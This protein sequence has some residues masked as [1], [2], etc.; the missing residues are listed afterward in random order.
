M[1]VIQIIYYL[2]GH[3]CGDHKGEKVSQVKKKIQ[4]TMVKSKEAV[5]YQEPEKTV[6]CCSGDEYV[7][8]LCDQW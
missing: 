5:L 8:A 7:V 4:A 2:L 6:I 3:A 1:Y